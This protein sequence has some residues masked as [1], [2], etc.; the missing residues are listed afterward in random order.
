MIAKINDFRCVVLFQ[1][2]P[3]SY[4]CA[5]LKIPTS[6][7]EV[8][9]NCSSS[10]PYVC[11]KKNITSTLLVALRNWQFPSCLLPASASPA[12]YPGSLAPSVLA[13]PMLGVILKRPIHRTPKPGTPEGQDLRTQHPCLPLGWSSGLIFWS[14]VEGDVMPHDEVSHRPPG[15]PCGR[16]FLRRRILAAQKGQSSAERT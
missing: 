11:L 8:T 5:R 10:D 7:L 3:I 13:K 16:F 9:I 12:S 15:G 14:H 6:Y 1:D 2:R 4:A